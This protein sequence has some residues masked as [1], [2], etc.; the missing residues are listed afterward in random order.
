M[1]RR[2]ITKR[3][4]DGLTATGA[5]Y[6]VWDSDLPAFAVRV[7]PSGAASYVVMTRAGSGRTAPL[8]RVTLGAVGKITPDQA[9]LLA[10]KVLADVAHGRDPAAERTAER[11]GLTVSGLIDLFMTEHVEA[12]R[13]GSTATLYRD[14]LERLVRPALG[15]ERVS[16]VTRPA[17]ARLHLRLKE[18]PYQA[19]RVLAVLGSMFAFAARRGLVPEGFNPARGIEKYREEGRE[20]YLTGE[21][22]DRLGAALREA[23]TVGIPWEVDE[24]KPTSKHV[25]KENRRTVLSPFATAAIRLLLFT[26]ARLREILHLRWE[27]VDFERGLLFLPDSK[28][29]RKTIVLG[30]PALAVLASLPRASS[31]VIAG[32]D[33]ERPRA[34]LKRPWAVVSD[35]AGLSGVRIHDLRHTHASIGAGA[36]LGLPVIG[37]LLGHAQASTT[38]RYAHLDADPLRRASETISGR[39]AADLGDAHAFDPEQAKVV[40]LRR[41]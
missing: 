7:R 9:R 20:R 8:R 27:H 17:V 34:D 11:Q 38:A 12:K 24:S 22:L 37:R 21:E 6:Q 5:E 4:V 40:P 3:L 26:G 16:K 30:A 41:N 31:F 2:R 10:K 14:Y 15:T 33:P 32:D 28:T 35:R 23:E 19:N 36:G 1:E 39:I 13:K 29:G 18:T 25:P